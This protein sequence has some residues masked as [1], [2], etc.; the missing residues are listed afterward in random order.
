MKITLDASTLTAAQVDLIEDTLNDQLARYLGDEIIGFQDVFAV[1][2]WIQATR[3]AEEAGTPAP[4]EPAG[5]AHRVVQVLIKKPLTFQRA[6]EL[7][8]MRMT[9]PLATWEQTGQDRLAPD[10]AEPPTGEPLPAPDA[11]Q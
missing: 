3:E 7:A 9:N 6:L 1:A 5:V 10:I 11:V 8:Q 2:G 4:P